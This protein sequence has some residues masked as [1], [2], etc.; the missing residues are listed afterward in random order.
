MTTL[1]DTKLS[2]ISNAESRDGVRVDQVLSRI[3]AR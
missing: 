2:A 3:A 1:L